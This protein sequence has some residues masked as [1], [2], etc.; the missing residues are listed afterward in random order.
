MEQHEQ[1]LQSLDLKI[2]SIGRWVKAGV[3]ALVVMVG[4][5]IVLLVRGH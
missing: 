5:V 1:R 3:I 4:A 2:I